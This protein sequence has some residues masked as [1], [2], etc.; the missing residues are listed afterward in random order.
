[1]S[2]LFACHIENYMALTPCRL[3]RHC[4]W[5]SWRFPCL[6][7]FTSSCSPSGYITEVIEKYSFQPI[8]YLLTFMDDLNSF[9]MHF[10]YTLYKHIISVRLHMFL[11]SLSVRQIYMIYIYNGH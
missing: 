10:F 9:Q 2:R 1:M 8:V 11:T 7:V 3:K 4:L 6:A 5:L